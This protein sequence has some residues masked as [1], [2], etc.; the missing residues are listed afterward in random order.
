MT[1]DPLF[2]FQLGYD[3]ADTSNFKDS[4]RLFTN[5]RGLIIQADIGSSVS[6]QTSVYE[7]QSRHPLFYQ[8]WIDSTEVIPGQ[9]RVKVSQDAGWDYN[10]AVGSLSIHPTKWIDLQIGHGKHFVGHGYRS[11]LLSDMAFNYPY[12]KSTLNLL[13][14]QIQ[15]TNIYAELQDLRRLPVGDVPESLFKR[16]GANFNYLNW[17]PHP[18][19]ELGLFEGIV[20]NQ[21]N[22]ST[23]TQ[24]FNYQQLIPVI[25]VNT[26]LESKDSL[27]QSL[28]GLN[29]KLKVNNEIQFYGQLAT[30]NR[31][32]NGET[33]SGLS[34]QAGVKSFNILIDNL[35]L[36]VEMN[37]SSSIDESINTSQEG[38]HHFNQALNHPL[39]DSFTEYIGIAN[40]RHNR[41][42]GQV[43]Y[44][45]QEK[46]H[47]MGIEIDRRS[48]IL[49]C[50]FGL[51]LN[52]KTNMNLV[53]G[54]IYRNDQQI[55]EDRKTQ[56]VYF[57]FRNFS[58]Q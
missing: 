51:H 31:F 52:P 57:G 36:Q 17:I 24:P 7:N 25:G 10:S 19:I 15:Y 14:D 43:K 27:H 21:W 34:W 6:F 46:S 4:V 50:Q 12:V 49:D 5:T 28:L 18:R 22:D 37:Q 33:N 53:L 3:F 45:F 41:W 56:W 1:F 48:E 11:L 13:K 32:Y 44:H 29:L 2:D 9:G 20:W 47:S 16:K 55:I 40:Y 39:G 58:T 38:Y 54:W 8:L 23:G 42:F 35:D 26:I 30:N